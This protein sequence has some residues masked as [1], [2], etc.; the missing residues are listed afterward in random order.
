LILNTDC[1]F[2]RIPVNRF[3]LTFGLIAV[4]L[5]GGIL[6]GSTRGLELKGPLIPALL[7][8]AGIYWLLPV[9]R[10]TANGIQGQP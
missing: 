5:G 7:I 8:A 1:A 3:T 6:V 4:L 9:R 2:S 10:E